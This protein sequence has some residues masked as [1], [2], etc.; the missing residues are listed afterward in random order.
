MR[1]IKIKVANQNIGNL[2]AINDGLLVAV[3]FIAND[4]FC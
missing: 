2:D 3:V 4:R 1:H